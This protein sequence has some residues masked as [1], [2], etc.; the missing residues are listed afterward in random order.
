MTTRSDCAI[1]V[2]PVVT[3]LASDGSDGITGEIIDIRHGVVSIMQQPKLIRSFDCG[4]LWTLENLDKVMPQL[5][6]A[7]KAHDEKVDAAAVPETI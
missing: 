6:K 1:A 4:G 2:A 3:W 7:K 5:M